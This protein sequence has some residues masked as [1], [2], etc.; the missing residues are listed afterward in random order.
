[1]VE[2]FIVGYV[3]PFYFCER[4]VSALGNPRSM[5]LTQ[6]KARMRFPISPS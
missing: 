4:G 2:I 5:N 6:S 3:R 1:L